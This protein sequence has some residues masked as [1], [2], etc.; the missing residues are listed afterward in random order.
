[1]NGNKRNALCSQ[2]G[3]FLAELVIAQAAIESAWKPVQAFR[4]PTSGNNGFGD[5][6][7]LQGR[8]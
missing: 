6:Y 5:D 1:M 3:M 4:I 2:V 8:R 7:A